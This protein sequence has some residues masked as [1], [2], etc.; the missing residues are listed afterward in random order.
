MAGAAKQAVMAARAPGR[1][2]RRTQNEDRWRLDNVMANEI[3]AESDTRAT[4]FS[5]QRDRQSA[6]FLPAI[7]AKIPRLSAP[8]R[9]G[10]VPRFPT[11]AIF[12]YSKPDSTAALALEFLILTA[13]RTSETLAQASSPRLPECLHQKRRYLR[14]TSAKSDR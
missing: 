12:T 14:R 5:V 10:S 13:T 8:A 4:E 1:A 9:F 3:S 11:Q 7:Q 2:E 6:A